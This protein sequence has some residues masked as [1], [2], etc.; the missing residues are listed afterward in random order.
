[1]ISMAQLILRDIESE[2]VDQLKLRAARHGRSAEAE[3]RQLLRDALTT[4]PVTTLKAH[5]LCMPGA[6]SDAD[7]ERV[8]EKP[9]KVKL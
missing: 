3:H 6:G 4:G 5:L 2:V 8:R 9:R 7:F 1:M